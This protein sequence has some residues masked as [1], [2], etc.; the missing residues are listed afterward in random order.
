MFKGV[1]K[2]PEDMKDAFRPAK[3]QEKARTRT[4]VS[5][6]SQGSSEVKLCEITPNM[7]QLPLVKRKDVAHPSFT[8]LAFEC[9]SLHTVLDT[10][11]VL[12]STT[13]RLTCH[14]F[15]QLLTF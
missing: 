12:F 5:M 7:K 8:S 15:V 14:P 2:V 13:H 10:S 11:N 4:S 1:S 6:L 9:L 3:V